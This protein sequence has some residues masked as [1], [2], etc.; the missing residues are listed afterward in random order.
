MSKSTMFFSEILQV[1]TV[2]VCIYACLCVAV[3][4]KINLRFKAILFKQE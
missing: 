2:H 4:I 1:L 3:I